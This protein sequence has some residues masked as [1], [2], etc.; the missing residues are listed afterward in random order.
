VEEPKTL[1]KQSQSEDL[2]TRSSLTKHVKWIGIGLGVVYWVVES[3]MDTYLYD[4]GPLFERMFTPDPNEAEMRSLAVGTIIAFGIF[5][6][7]MIN[8]L[9]K[10]EL[11]LARMNDCFLGFNADPMD[12]INRLTTLCGELLEAGA[13]LYNR[14]DEGKLCPW[15][16]WQMSLEHSPECGAEGLICYD[17]IRKSGNDTVVI[18]N[19]LQSAY[20]QTDPKVASYG[21]RT[22]AGRTVRLG[23]IDVGALCVFYRDD[24]T[25][26][27]EDQRLM[28]IIASAIGVEEVRKRAED[29]LRESERQ[30]RQLSSQLLSA[31]ETER[32]RIARQ[33]HDSIGQ[34]L[35]A[36]KFSIEE[37]L[38]TV[39]GSQ[40]KERFGALESAVALIQEVVEE[41]R[42]LQ[43]N[44]RP[45]MLDDLGIVATIRSFCREFEAIYSDISIQ[46]DLEVPELEVPEPIK[47]AIYRIVQEA[48]NNVAK[49]SKAG[50]VRIGLRRNGESLEL[51][52]QD[53]GVG[54][55]PK[56]ARASESGRGVG[57][58]SMRERT[59]LSGGA[60]TIES[61]T[62]FGTTVRALWPQ[63]TA[64]SNG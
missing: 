1:L 18:H 52:I 51:A 42:R 15:G 25:P 46:K 2:M 62:G 41:V 30:L 39:A 33:L 19:L 55:D 56:L 28:G 60:F 3:M 20:A 11:R 22:Y 37:T 8:K 14:L 38:E 54:F 31:Q 58:S 40:A 32:K 50:L 47:T 10:A 23:E 61:T 12:N 26:T 59:E 17:V 35:S 63:E 13:A 44:L 9:E 49:H 53:H 21:L 34:S 16:Q 27:E 4:M 57:L 29:A 64:S 48:M 5:A 36:V 6:Q 45:A 7:S 24:R 43:K